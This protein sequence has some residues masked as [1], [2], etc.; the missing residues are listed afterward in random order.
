MINRIATLA[1]SIA[2]AAPVAASAIQHATTPIDADTRNRLVAAGTLVRI[3]MLQTVSSATNKKG[4]TFGFSV[5]DNVM[6]GDRVAIP[7]GTRGTGEVLDARRAHMAGEDG[8]L[9]VKFHPLVLDD[10]T[11][12]ELAITRE[13]LVADEND[14]NYLA[15]NIA[16]VASLTVPGFFLVDL[17]RKGSDV[18]LK[19]NAPFHV[20]VTED[21]F[22]SDSH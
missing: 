20:G 14:K 22:L 2:L 9:Q 5:V 12:V 11:Q 17:L 13:S 21:A 3:E 1:A 15:G 19:A 10:G 7:A 18:T 6:A 16:E 4:D 8:A